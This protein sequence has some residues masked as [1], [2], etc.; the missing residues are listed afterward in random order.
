MGDLRSKIRSWNLP[1]FIINYC[2]IINNAFY[3]YVYYSYY[4][5]NKRLLKEC[6]KEE[7]LKITGAASTLSL[8]EDCK[9]LNEDRPT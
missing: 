4:I 1:Q 7:Y 6:D 8:K 3:N 9:T 2:I 5:S